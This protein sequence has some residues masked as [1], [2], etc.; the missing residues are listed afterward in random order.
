MAES[1]FSFL[2]R[3]AAF[4]ALHGC[5]ET[6]CS[7]ASTR[8]RLRRLARCCP[9]GKWAEDA[10][11]FRDSHSYFSQPCRRFFVFAQRGTLPRGRRRWLLHAVVMTFASVSPVQRVVA[12]LLAAVEYYPSFVS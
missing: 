3:F 10:A 12:Q 1:R 4:T 8:R 6:E 2:A 5:D 9:A 11:H 7:I